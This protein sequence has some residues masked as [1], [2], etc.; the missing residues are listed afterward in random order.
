MERETPRGGRH[1]LKNLVIVGALLGAGF[2]LAWLRFRPHLA[3]DGH[4]TDG[5]GSLE[6]SEVERL[7]YAIWDAP[8]VVLG[9]LNGPGSETRTTVSPDGRFVVFASGERG[10]DA[11]LYV[12]ALDGERVT[13]VRALDELN[14]PFDEVAPRFGALGL[15]FAS[16]RPGGEGGLDLFRASFDTGGLAG[17]FGGVSF[18]T[19]RRI[20]GGLNSSA[21]DTDPAPVP[22]TATN[23]REQLVFASNRSARGTPGAPRVH[24]LFHARPARDANGAAIWI[25]DPLDELNSPQDERDP[26]FGADGAS[27]LFASDRGDGAGLG[28]TRDD[29]FD[30][31]RSAKLTGEL[32]REATW[33]PVERLDAVNTDAD[34][35]GPD[36]SSD[37]FALRFSRDL[38]AG[39]SGEILLARSRE[40]FRTPGDPVGWRE[41]LVIGLLLL[42]ALLAWAAKRWHAMDVIYRCFVVSL[43]AHLLL[44]WWFQRVHPA[45]E[46]DELV[47][48][49]PRVRVQLTDPNANGAE[50]EALGGQLEVARSQNAE[51]EAAPAREA[52]ESSALAST[53]TSAA[54]APA[55]FERSAVP[56]VVTAGDRALESRAERSANAVAAA[57]VEL[58]SAVDAEAF[59]RAAA[60]RSELALPTAPS[61][62]APVRR[63]ARD[64]DADGPRRA[65]AG[66]LVAATPDVASDLARRSLLDGARPVERAEAFDRVDPGP[67]PRLDASGDVGPRAPERAVATARPDL[68]AP[69]LLTTGD[70]GASATDAAVAAVAPGASFERADAS[71]RANPAPAPLTEPRTSTTELAAAPAPAAL[72]FA[73]AAFER[74]SPS[75]PTLG[76]PL[77]PSAPSAVR[78]DVALADVPRSAA[79]DDVARAPLV[80]DTDDLAQAAR[81]AS[82]ERARASDDV[83][84]SAPT[85]ERS[86]GPRTDLAPARP[87]ALDLVAA[88]PPA[89]PEP[90][91]PT[92]L[93]DL[94]ATPYRSRTGAAKQ[95]ALR[96][97]GGDAETEAAVR[98]GLRYLASIQRGAGHWGDR[99]DDHDKY[100][101]VRIGKTGL[102]LLAFL[103]AGHTPTS[104]TEHSATVE[105]GLRYLLDQQLPSGHIGDC[106]SY[107]H[108]IATYALAEAF[109]LTPGANWR[110]Q[111]EA[112]V[113]HVLAMQTT[114][115]TRREIGGWGYY[116]G[117]GRFFD[118]YARTSITSWQVMALESARLGGI[119]VP[120]A[121]FERARDF[122]LAAWDEGLGA[123]RYSHDRARLSSG[124]PTL[125]GSTPAAMFGLSLL[126][127]DIASADFDAPRAWVLERA[128]RSYRY[129]NDDAF[130]ER[131]QGNLYFVYYASLALFR[132][133]GDAWDEWNVALKELLLDE[134]NGD[135]S[136]TPISTYAR[137][138]AGDDRRDASY[139]TAMAV[140]SLEVYYRYF[141]PL[142]D[143]GLSNGARGGGPA[144]ASGR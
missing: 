84:P 98:D 144:A 3:H 123:F 67:A 97:F 141:T 80:E 17:L 62:A 116:T 91:V 60:T 128:P 119:D 40:L 72:G 105:R 20:E 16:N 32:A 13:D 127:V 126:G 140:L 107:G 52:A 132:T 18:A 85:F 83:R 124:W 8:E 49:G 69:A 33:G 25:V 56:S 11:D 14:G 104:G 5:R 137:D 79:T 19:P 88:A 26:A 121:A 100:G 143:V 139:T 63:E 89:V 54:P 134:Q 10:V 71:E 15:Y 142:L 75:V 59:T 138:H 35:R 12:G 92:A 30:L 34:E 130:V 73:P 44:V 1:W 55:T 82:F 57:P 51:A 41:L 53:D 36:P 113:G 118:Q 66:A 112:A 58:A 120:D 135:G 2:A 37:G 115:G 45:A 38:G 95:E 129:T 43:V 102:C 7:R 106:A 76:A 74:T 64:L 78:R 109:A 61:D 39:A 28:R 110:R 24:D 111:L 117:D 133:G 46:V 22:G 48:Q 77:A 27:I 31:Y 81:P 9:D 6:L 86:S 96:E 99:D 101:D 21:D 23:G 65:E 50:R 93:A 94:D 47:R 108:G 114:S 68:A 87:A 131:G 122:L 29:D 4:F 103:G 70:G 42:L 90:S 136:W 125:P